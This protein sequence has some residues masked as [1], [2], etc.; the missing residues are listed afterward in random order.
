[1][2]DDYEGKIEWAVGKF[3]A[4]FTAAVK[5]GDSP[6]DAVEENVG[7]LFYLRKNHP[8]KE[9]PVTGRDQLSTDALAAIAEWE[10]ANGREVLS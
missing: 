9:F 7:L 10:K 6:V 5:K 3:N 2:V 1:M 4:Q 8:N